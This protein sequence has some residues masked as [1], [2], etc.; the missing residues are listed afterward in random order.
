MKFTEQGGVSLRISP[1]EE[2]DGI[3]F[4][5]EDT[6]VGIAEENL[7]DIFRPFTQLDLSYTRRHGGTGLGLTICQ[8]IVEA[9]GGTISVD[10]KVGRGSR[11]S[12][13]LT[14]PA[15]TKERITSLEADERSIMIVNRNTVAAGNIAGQ[16]AAWR[17]SLV[18]APS[19]EDGRA[20]LDGGFH[21]DIVVLDASVAGPRPVDALHD[22]FGGRNASDFDVY[23]ML[24]MGDGAE[25]FGRLGG[26][27]FAGYLLDPPHLATLKRLATNGFLEERTAAQKTDR[28]P[29]ESATLIPQLKGAR[30]LLAED[31]QTNQLVART[32]LEGA[33]CLVEIAEDGV[34]AVAAAMETR[35][36]LILM[37]LSMP[38]MDGLSATRHIR[39]ES[40]LSS[41]V[42]IIAVTAHTMAE[43]RK[44]CLDG[45]MDDVLGKP[46]RRAELVGVLA[47]W[48]TRGTS[49]QHP[50]TSPTDEGDAVNMKPQGPEDGPAV[51]DEGVVAQL[52]TDIG[53]ERVVE[54]VAVFVKETEDRVVRIREAY[55]DGRLEDLSREAHSMKSS[56]G[57]HSAP[58]N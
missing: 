38:N 11:F 25:A 55:A 44:S 51:L 52:E 54:L 57:T 12:V 20:A 30:V 29:A 9:M 4:Q 2:T 32:I 5:I 53:A 19:L 39:S 3:K 58:W 23:L 24:K 40:G 41:K 34:K 48:I 8:A 14:L 21:P 7:G 28:S 36:D 50:T 45:G 13:T 26:S 42:P 16:F 15:T 49:D 27:P 37:D 47:R 10:S 17:A 35:Y 1:S 46:Y 56:S 18:V 6:G 33:G 31:S 22:L 43:D